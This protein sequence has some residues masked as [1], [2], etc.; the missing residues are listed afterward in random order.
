MGL[1]QVLTCGAMDFVNFWTGHIPGGFKSRKFYQHNPIAVLM[2]T[3]QQENMEAG[4]AMAEKLNSSLGPAAFFIPLKGF[5]SY[6]IEGGPSDDLEA[7]QAFINSLEKN[8]RPDIKVIKCGCHINDK[9][10]A[11]DMVEALEA[12]MNE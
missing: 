10:F 8:L 12:M 7:D 4:R 6:D 2:R 9:Q 3:N 1:P 11:S 5:S